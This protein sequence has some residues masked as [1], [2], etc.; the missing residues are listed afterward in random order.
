MNV[1][2][3]EVQEIRTRAIVR[4]VLRGLAEDARMTGQAYVDG[5]GQSEQIIVTVAM[6]ERAAGA[7]VPRDHHLQGH[8]PACGRTSLMTGSGGHITCGHLECPDPTALDRLLD[9]GETEHLLTVHRDGS[10]T[11]R[12]PLKERLDGALE[13]CRVHETAAHRST[14]LPECGRYRTRLSVDYGR[15]SFD[16]ITDPE[17]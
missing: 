3:E 16:R 10:F 6:L 17:N 7:V 8:C 9:D 15:L 13:S 11:L 4:D 14:R 12:H 1:K 2:W 5:T